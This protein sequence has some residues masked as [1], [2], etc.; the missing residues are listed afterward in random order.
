MGGWGFNLPSSPVHS[1]VTPQPP[2]PLVPAVLLTLPVHFSQ[3]EPCT[4]E[5]H[6]N[7]HFGVYSD[8]SVI[9]EQPY[10]EGLIHRKYKQWDPCL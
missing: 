4:L 9:T 10:N 7:T 5:P 3:F 1:I 2:N 8:I 6:Y